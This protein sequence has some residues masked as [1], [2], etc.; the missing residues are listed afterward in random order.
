[1]LIQMQ[2]YEIYDRSLHNLAQQIKSN[3]FSLI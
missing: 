2:L 1:M 3:Q